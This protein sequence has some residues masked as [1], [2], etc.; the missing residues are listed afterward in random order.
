MYRNILLSFLGSLLL[1]NL[2]GC[3]GTSSE[4]SDFDPVAFAGN[5]N[6]AYTR[7]TG[8]LTITVA[9]NG[10]IDIVLVDSVEGTF[11]GTGVAN[12]VGGFFITCSGTNNKSV[13]INGTLRG[14][15]L[16]RTAAGTIAGSVTVNYNATFTSS[17]DAAIW[18]N[19]YEG[20][21]GEGNNAF[22]WFGDVSANG[23][24]TGM[25]IITN[26]ENV[27]M[28][29]NVYSNGSLSVT[30]TGNGRTYKMKGALRLSG[31]GGILGD[32]LMEISAAAGTSS[33]SWSGHQAQGG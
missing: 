22:N 25:L 27:N 31:N 19:H 14:S 6:A 28:T 18:T 33:V 26:G 17:P 15:G 12:H 8:T 29:G 32:G 13:S 1:F 11:I 7:A 5:Y 21:F 30:G 2:F 3:A 9:A 20:L 10:Q 4:V 16:G 24:F 23:T